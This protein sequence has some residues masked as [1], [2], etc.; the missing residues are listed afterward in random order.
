MDSGKVIT[1]Y[2]RDGDAEGV[3]KCSI[4]NSIV[5][6]YSFPHTRKKECQEIEHLRHSGIYVLIGTN[7]NEEM[8]VY[9]GQ[10]VTRKNGDG[11]LRRM[12]E[13]H[14]SI[15]YWTRAIAI[16]TT[17]NCFGP[18][19]VCYLENQFAEMARKAKRSKVVNGNEPSSG[20]VTEEMKCKL[21]EVISLSV[22]AMSALGCNVFEPLVEDQSRAQDDDLLYYQG[23]DFDARC[24]RTDEGFVVR[25]GSTISKKCAASCPNSALRLREQY[26]ESIDAENKLQ[27]D[28]VFPSPSGAADFVSGNSVSGNKVWHNAD[29]E[30]LETI[31]LKE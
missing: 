22:L 18:T 26:S 12:S 16:T 21:N 15:S 9:I 13:K 4:M 2:L 11:L 29:G 17:D 31:L 20:V 28:I 6:L 5:V 3:I 23:K 7:N 14:D 1:L 24:V 30:S 8:T 27:V 10:A 19:E 25:A